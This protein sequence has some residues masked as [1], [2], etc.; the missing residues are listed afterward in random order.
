MR[1]LS[2]RV[3]AVWLGLFALLLAGPAVVGARLSAQTGAGGRIVG[4]AAGLRAAPLNPAFVRYQKELA[5]G[6]APSEYGVHG[7]GLVPAPIDPAGLRGTQPSGIPR[8]Y[9]ASYDLRTLGRVT[10]GQ[11]PG[12]ERHLLGLRHH[13]LARILSPA[14]HNVRFL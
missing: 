4:A 10:A 1:S 13:G 12:P 14:G 3:A 7:L 11:G 6:M 9:P 8:A 5:Q 2:V